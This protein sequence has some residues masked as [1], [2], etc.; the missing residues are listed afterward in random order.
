MSEASNGPYEVRLRSRR[1]QRELNSIP[2]NDFPRILGAIEALAETPRPASAV[3]V[4]ENIFR[5]RV[6]RFRVL[7]QIDDELR[8][9]DIGGIRRR[10]E[11][12]YRRIRDLFY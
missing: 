9:V 12:T 2:A 4:D 3:R 5:L 1:V 11:R 8:R 7:Y 6:G 10:S